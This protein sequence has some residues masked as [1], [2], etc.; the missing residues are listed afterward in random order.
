METPVSLWHV[1]RYSSPMNT[2]IPDCMQ[3]TRPF[4]IALLCPVAL[5]CG[6]VPDDHPYGKENTQ[7][8]LS[9]EMKEHV[10]RMNEDV[11]RGAALREVD[12]AEKGCRTERACDQA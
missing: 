11:A 2:R 9:R 1:R 10:D 4:A 6:C 12:E 5:L 3:R 8:G 7:P